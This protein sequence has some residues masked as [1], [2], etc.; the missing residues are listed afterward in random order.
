MSE[1]GQTLQ[2]GNP[3]PKAPLVVGV[4]A[5]TSARDSIERFLA[6]LSLHP[7]QA[8]VLVLQHR[9]ALDEG[10]LRGIVARLNDIRLAEPSDEARIEGGTIYL[11]AADAITTIHNDRFAVRP[12]QQAP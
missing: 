12:A 2:D 9:E 4:G 7:G 6:K 10:W 8:V 1:L 3:D 5:S 11:C